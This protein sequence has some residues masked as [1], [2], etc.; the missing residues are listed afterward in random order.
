ML[1]LYLAL[2]LMLWQT[3]SVEALSAVLPHS[4]VSCWQFYQCPLQFDGSIV[5][6]YL[7]GKLQGTICC[8]ALVQGTMF[9]VP[10]GC[11]YLAL[12]CKLHRCLMHSYIACLCTMATTVFRTKRVEKLA[13]D[14]AHFLQSL[15][16]YEHKHVPP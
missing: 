12:S 6:H 9:V 1:F 4:L 14:T 16:S 15:V 7:I 8:G 11:D 13:L 10:T 3:S 2:L 5:G